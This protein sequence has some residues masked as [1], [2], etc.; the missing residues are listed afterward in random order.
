MLDGARLYGTRLWDGTRAARLAPV[1]GDVEPRL[2]STIVVTRDG[3]AGLEVLLLERTGGP[4]PW[5][6]PGGKL[7]PGD[8]NGAVDEQDAL[9][10]AAVR[11]AREEAALDLDPQ[12]LTLISRWITPKVALE[13][14]PKRFDTWFYLAHVPSDAEVRVDGGEIARHRWYAPRDAL[15]A[16]RARELRLAPPTFVSIHWLEGHADGASA[17]RALAAAELVTFRPQIHRMDDGACILYPGDAGYADE[18]VRRPGPRH[19]LWMR[20]E[21]WEYERG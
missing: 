18:D 9:R 15:D 13:G 20:P 2:S 1:M 17:A 5:V 4:R 8:R 10:R 6:F 14:A 11:E 3:T 19:R 21:G 12:G 7:D 16:Q